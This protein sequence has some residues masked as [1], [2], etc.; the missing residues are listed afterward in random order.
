MG[1][2]LPDVRFIINWGSAWSILNQH[3]EAGRAG[4]DGKRAN[5][6]VTYHWQQVGHR[7]QQIKD[8]VHTKG[9]FHVA[10]YKSSDDT[11]QPLEPPRECC[12]FCSSI[13]KCNA[14]PLPFEAITA[15][16][17]ATM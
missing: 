8:F 4:R 2:N 15:A 10:A 3:R 7:E 13:C 12:S 17:T 16:V 11:I 5:V 1:V 9:C 6:V 14:D